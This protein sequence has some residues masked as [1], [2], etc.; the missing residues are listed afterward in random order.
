MSFFKRKNK[1][2]SNH[3]GWFGDYKNWGELVAG[4]GGYES[5]NILEK[6]KE[7]L[8]KIKNGEAVYERDSVL[9]DKKIY[10]YSIISSLLYASIHCG[11]QLNIID[12]GGS[13][14]STYYQVKDFIPSEIDV[15][16]SVVEQKNYVTCGQET[17]QNESLKF[18]ETIAESLASKRADILLLSGV[19]QYLE[20]PHEFLAGLAAFDF[21][22]ILI[23]RTAFIC[24]NQ[25]DRLTLQIVPPTIYEAQYPSWF[26]NEQLF[27]EH[28]K[29]Y[30]LKAEFESYVPGEQDIHIDHQVQGYDKGFFLIKKG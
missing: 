2:E 17:F 19:V 16:W 1:R 24:N 18:H 14:G 10:P 20:K 8:L 22:F 13:L 30:A 29:N 5:S 7:A 3:Y 27:L 28:F 4:S 21:K 9:F 25:A 11:N 12:F 6:T 15:H 23:D 26:F